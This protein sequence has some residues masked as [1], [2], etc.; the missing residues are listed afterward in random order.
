M[1][2]GIYVKI[3][4]WFCFATAVMS[5][6]VVL[7]TVGLHSQ[8]LG[9]RWMTGVLDQYARSAVDIYIH[10]GKT[11]LAEYL[12]EIE[13]SS[14]L[15]ATLLDPQFRNITGRGVPP[16]AEKVLAEARAT[17]QT[18]FRTGMRWTGASVV[19]GP[20][21]KFILVAKVVPY[22]GLLNWWALRVPV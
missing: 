2:R 22:G 11:R 16:E 7:I 12:E 19:S 21:G 14:R 3:F 20:E 5:G 13:R 17:R 9:P 10:G 18:R 8:T 1:I 6:S 4:L 15:Q